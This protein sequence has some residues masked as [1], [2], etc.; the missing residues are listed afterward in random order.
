[1]VV[2]IASGCHDFPFST[3]QLSESTLV[4]VIGEV[5]QSLNG[6]GDEIYLFQLGDKRLKTINAS[7]DFDR[8]ADDLYRKARSND[9]TGN[10]LNTEQLKCH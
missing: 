2:V 9:S 5:G 8:I 7:S 3:K 1:M 6:D 4:L 10:A